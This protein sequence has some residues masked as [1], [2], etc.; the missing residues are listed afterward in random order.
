MPNNM[1][2][3]STPPNYFWVQ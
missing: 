3:F 2:E 1:I